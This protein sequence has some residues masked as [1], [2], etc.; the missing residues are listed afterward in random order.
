MA[1]LTKYAPEGWFEPWSLAWHIR[2]LRSRN[3][4]FIVG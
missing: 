3:R 4:E 1:Y 2:Q